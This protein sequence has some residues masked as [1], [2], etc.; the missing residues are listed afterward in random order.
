MTDTSH[1]GILFNPRAYAPA[2]L[3]DD[4]RALME[5]TVAYFESLGKDR[6]TSED[7]AG[8]WYDDFCR[9]LGESGAFAT[10]MTPAGYGDDGARWD[11]W[12]NCHFNEIT[13]FYSLGYWYAWQVSMLGLGPIWMGENEELK[14]RTAGLLR[15]GAIFA[16]G[17]SEKDHGA[18]IYSTEMTLTPTGDGGYVANGSKYYIG[19]GNEAAL[20]SVFGKTVVPGDTDD[21]ADSEQVDYVFFTVESGHDAYELEK[22]TVHSPMFV[23]AFSL[24]DYPVTDADIV[25]RGPEA[26]NV[27]LNTINVCKYNLGWASIGICTHAFYEAIN[28]AGHRELYGGLVTDFAHVRQLFVDA[29]ARLTAMKLFASRA[30]DYMRTASDDDRR[31]LLYNPMVKMKVTTEGEHVVNALWDV[32]AAKGFEKDTYFNMAARHIRALPKLEGTVHVNIALIVKFMANYFFDPQEYPEVPIRRDATHDDYLFHQAPT[33]GLGK[34]RFHDWEATFDRFESANVTIFRGQA[35]TFKTMLEAAAPDETQGAD[36]DFLLALG[37]L[38]ALVVYAQLILENVELMDIS[39]PVTEQIFDVLVRDFSAG[40]T[41][42]HG[43]STTNDK[44]AAF[45]LQMVQRPHV[46]PARFGFVWDEA[47]AL[48]DTYELAP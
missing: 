29:Y 2:E 13:A 48:I 27:A 36:I 35:E 9:F 5:A 10:L 34:I 22:N 24:R 18:D 45:A 30:N 28:H 47:L 44:Q 42:L 21:P 11:T 19:N 4:S 20:V 17:L 32:I 40:A 15:E 23:S 26:W 41:R 7:N 12:R 25:V 33:R 1:P 38:F 16:F 39:E 6:I 46:D 37:E 31:Y 3:D 8:V 43:K 14:A